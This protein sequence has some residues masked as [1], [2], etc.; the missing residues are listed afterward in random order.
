MVVYY[1]LGC[2]RW[3]N[4]DVLLLGMIWP[5][6]E[7]RQLCFAMSVC[8]YIPYLL[9]FQ[10]FVYGLSLPQPSVA[11]NNCWCVVLSTALL[12][13]TDGRYIWR[14]CGTPGSS[15]TFSRWPDVVCHGNPYHVWDHYD[16]YLHQCTLQRVESSCLA[17]LVDVACSDCGLPLCSCWRCRNDIFLL[18]TLLR[19]FSWTSA[20]AMLRFHRLR[21]WDFWF[22]ID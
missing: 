1:L 22:F 5:L 15:M 17:I 16:W 12:A 20:L 3:W 19:R 10:V 18:S 6:M 2:G 21:C 11:I 9:V 4:A 14:G 8:L 7:L 13:F